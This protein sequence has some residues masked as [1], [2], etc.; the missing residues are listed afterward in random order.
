M[1]TVHLHRILQYTM[2]SPIYSKSQP[3]GSS[4]MGQKP[5]ASVLA[6]APIYFSIRK[7][8]VENTC[9]LKLQLAAILKQQ[10]INMNM[11]LGSGPTT[12]VQGIFRLTTS[13]FLV[14]RYTNYAII[15]LSTK[16]EINSDFLVERYTDYATITLSTKTKI[17]SFP[18]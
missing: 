13:D 5:A 4:T 11:S 14:E 3:Q 6:S 7:H 15:M 1:D 17:L 8:K 9:Q 18:E 10:E 2:N 16:T 12:I